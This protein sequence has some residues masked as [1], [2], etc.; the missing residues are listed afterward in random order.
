MNNVDFGKWYWRTIFIL[1][2]IICILIE[3]LIMR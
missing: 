1:G 3:L 2:A